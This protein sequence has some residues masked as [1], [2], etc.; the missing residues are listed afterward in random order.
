[1]ILVRVELYSAV[2]KQVT[3]LA[4]MEIVN[5]ETGTNK[6]RNYDA[7]TLFGRSKEALNQRRTQR[8]ARIENWPSL[9]LHVWN[10]VATALKKMKYGEG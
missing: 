6:R 2:T 5:D 8:H 7:R 10:L 4:R 1:M 9:N 3:E